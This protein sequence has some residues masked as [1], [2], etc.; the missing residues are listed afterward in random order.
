[1]TMSSWS[2]S[3]TSCSITWSTG[4]P[5]DQLLAGMGGDE[6]LGGGLCAV[7]DA[8]LETVAF[9]VQHQV[10]AHDGQA[11]QSEIAFVV[12]RW[13][14]QPRAEGGNPRS[15]GVHHEIPR[16]HRARHRQ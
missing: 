10:L 14:L 12:H 13:I 16:C 4:A 5:A 1:M 2:S 3:G 15:E 7:V 11:D 6:G 8:D 9:H